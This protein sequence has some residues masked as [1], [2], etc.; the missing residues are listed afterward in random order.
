MPRGHLRVMLGAAPG[1]GKTYAMLEEG[2]RLQSLGTDVVVAVAETH[3]RA[4]TAAM[5][6]GLEVVP[7]HEVEHR[8]VTLTEL[9]LDA[10]LR[11]APQVALVDE[12]AHTN[13][14]GTEHA[15]R[16]EDVEAMLEA[17]ID[18][19]STVNIQHIQSLNDVVEQITGVHQ[20]ETIPDA[21]LR[22]ADQIEVV[23]LAPQA[24]R[25]RLSEGQVYPATRIDAALSNYFRLGNLT[26][27]RELALLWLADEVDSSLK[28][29]R[30]EHGIQGTWEARERVVV[31][32]TGG[33][34]GDT[35]IRRAARIAARSSGG[36]LL[37]V[38]VT[39]P[40]GLTGASPAALA[41]QRRLAESLGG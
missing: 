10:V 22:R 20:R 3:G 27:L 24:L 15:K 5:L 9:D 19:M 12:L 18:V 6:E 8:G 41:E 34:E 14:P 33:P 7:R 16:W 25:D 35:L 29:Y 1:V 37:A 31:A 23:D 11:R 4:A 32:L 36:D 21:V 2:K 40:D 26:A 17:G 28:R 38:H 13:A 30:A 39:R